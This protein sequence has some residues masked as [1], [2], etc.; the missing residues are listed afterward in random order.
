MGTDGVE[1][2]QS[3]L[4]HTGDIQSVC[5]LVVR[6][7]E[8]SLAVK[9]V[10]TEE[11]VA[12]RLQQWFVHYKD[13]LDAWQMWETRATFDCAIQMAQMRSN[14]PQQVYIS[15]TYCGGSVA[16][17]MKV[18]SSIPT[19]WET[20]SW[21][22]MYTLLYQGFSPLGWQRHRHGRQQPPEQPRHAR[23]LHLHEAG[24]HQA[25]HESA[26][27]PAVPQGPAALRRLPPLDGHALRT[28]AQHGAPRGGQQEGHPL[29]V[30]LH[31][32]PDLQARR[33]RRTHHKLVCRA[34]RLPH[35]RLR[36]QVCHRGS[37][38]PNRAGE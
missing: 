16:R 34:R 23:H 26:G 33:P 17:N 37:P 1:L 27:M 7:L 15:C 6:C 32:V 28:D 36:L 22:T 29:Q 19:S 38:L 35:L 5:W 13:L 4:D 2:L 11:S 12:S 8:P 10:E 3:Y 31:V 30:D 20:L 9:S 24:Q 25:N 14:A 21:L 18:R